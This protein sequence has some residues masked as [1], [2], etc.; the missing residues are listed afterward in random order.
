[1]NNDKDTSMMLDIFLDNIDD[2]PLAINYNNNNT[3]KIIKR[4]YNALHKIENTK[5]TNYTQ[6]I[7][8]INDTNTNMKDLRW[9]IQ[10]KNDL[11]Q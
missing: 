9:D 7:V 1:M 2:F 4:F 6:K 5:K 3:K 8:D 10:L 11:I